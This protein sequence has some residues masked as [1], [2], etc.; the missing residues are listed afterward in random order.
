[1]NSPVDTPGSNNA[2]RLLVV[3]DNADSAEMLVEYL[4]HQGYHVEV[5]QNGAEALKR[6]TETAALPNLILLDL[7]MPVMDGWTLRRALLQ[8][9]RLSGVPVVVVSALANLPPPEQVAENL[10]KPIELR[11]LLETI[12]KLVP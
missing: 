10:Q 3:E 12:R 2:R 11:R 8:D 7:T 6:L 9:E 1:M 5:A 4:E